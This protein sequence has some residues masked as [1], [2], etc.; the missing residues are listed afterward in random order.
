MK[1]DKHLGKCLEKCTEV[2]VVFID[3]FIV[4]DIRSKNKGCY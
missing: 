2:R 1:E 3:W 4:D